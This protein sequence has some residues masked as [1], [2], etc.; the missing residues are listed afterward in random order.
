MLDGCMIQTVAGLTGLVITLDCIG[1]I[2]KNKKPPI[3]S[4]F[5]VTFELLD[6][7]LNQP[8]AFVGF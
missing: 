7:E 4:G 1:I 2:Y 8:V 3:V 5:F 6:I